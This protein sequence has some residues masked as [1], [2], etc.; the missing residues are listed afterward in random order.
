MWCRK[1]GNLR[2]GERVM[3]GR[4]KGGGQSG[5]NNPFIDEMARMRLG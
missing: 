2:L 5:L 3:E 1:E 4:M